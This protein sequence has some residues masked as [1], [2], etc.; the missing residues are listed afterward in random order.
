MN[1]NRVI[2]FSVRF[3]PRRYNQDSECEVYTWRNA[4]HKKQTHHLLRDDVTLAL[5]SQGFSCKNTLFVSLKGPGVK[6][7]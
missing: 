4:K 1:C 3:V 6:T 5:W 7:S 2:L